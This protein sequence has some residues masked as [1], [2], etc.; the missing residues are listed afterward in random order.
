MEAIREKQ[1]AWADR[2]KASTTRDRGTRR[3][4]RDSSSVR[5]PPA[6]GEHEASDVRGGGDADVQS[7]DR[8]ESCHKASFLGEEEKSRR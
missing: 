1:G 4:A 8:R 6:A 3:G 5:M 2:S 7:R